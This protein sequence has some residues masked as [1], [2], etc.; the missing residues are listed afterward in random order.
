MAA[1]RP[2]IQLLAGPADRIRANLWICALGALDTGPESVG[3]GGGGGSAH[4]RDLSAGTSGQIRVGAF[5]L[6]HCRRYAHLLLSF[7]AELKCF[8]R[9]MRTDQQGCE[10]SF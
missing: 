6:F 4:I 7:D 3:L 10:F 9:H 5:Q 1:P 8:V 2:A